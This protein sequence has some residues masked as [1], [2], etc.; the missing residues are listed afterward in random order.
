MIAD[1]EQRQSHEQAQRSEDHKSAAPAHVKKR[2]GRRR[3]SDE[4]S[5]TAR[6]VM[7]RE[8]PTASFGIVARENARAE[9]MLRTGAGIDGDARRNQLRVAADEVLQHRR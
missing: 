7:K 9:W 8:R 6:R 1:P 4:R 3:R 5:E 2:E